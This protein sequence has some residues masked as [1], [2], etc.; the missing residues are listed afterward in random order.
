MN[1]A[2]HIVKHLNANLD[3]MTNFLKTLVLHE[4]PSKD[5]E[6]QTRILGVMSAEL[7]KLG[8]F[9]QYIS[10]KET[11]GYLF[12]RPLV[13]QKNSPFQLVIGHC[14]TVWDLHT[15]RKMPVTMKDGT[16]TGPGVYDMKAGLTQLIFA[17]KTINELSLPVALTPLILINSDEEI[18]SRESTRMIQRLAKISNRAF[19]LEPPLGL[20]GK[21]KTARKGLGRFTITAIGK[22]AHA[23][24]DPGKGVNAI[25][26]LSHQIQQLYAMND[27]EKGITV[28][29]GMIQGG[30]S[31]NVV[32]PESKAIVDV[33]VLNL[34]DGE[35]ITK[36]IHA[37]TPSI[38]NIEL[39]IEG[40]I[41]R[42]PMERTPRN[43]KLWQFAKAKGSLMGLDLD[44]GIAGG[45][46]DG[47]TT[48][49]FTATLDGLGTTGD[50]AHAAHE[51]IILEKLPERTALLIQL[52]ISD[53][54]DNELKKGK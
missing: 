14:D 15:L 27:F 22:A 31:P 8:Y 28:N 52:L 39:K 47:N 19:V 26:E 35:I 36:K 40:G 10:G 54:V 20:E 53:T 24:L 41:G 48:S 2:S 45:G 13:R 25:V 16:M 6:S 34:K 3:T 9:T 49:Q 43:Q 46:S 51:H 5:P 32:A 23:G 29:I 12:A 21:L 1:L 7:N 4:S 18:G 50:G 38:P 44:Q 33:R 17:L 37:L 11:G 42:P 30:I